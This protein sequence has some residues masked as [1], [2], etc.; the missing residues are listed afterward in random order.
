MQSP[1]EMETE[2]QHLLLSNKNVSVRQLGSEVPAARVPL[3]LSASPRPACLAASL[4]VRVV[5]RA[6]FAGSLLMWASVCL[7]APVVCGPGLQ[8]DSG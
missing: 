7:S 6:G 5:A 3:S 2:T 1:D 8:S 4:I